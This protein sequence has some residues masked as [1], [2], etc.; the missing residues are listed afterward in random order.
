M[1]SNLRSNLTE[2]TEQ[3]NLDELESEVTEE[4]IDEPLEPMQ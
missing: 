1:E 4:F 2:K 3:Q